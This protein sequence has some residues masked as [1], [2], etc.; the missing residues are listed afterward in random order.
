MVTGD[1]HQV[2]QAVAADL[3]IDEVFAEEAE[4]PAAG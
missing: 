4:W 2:A 1:A 3:D